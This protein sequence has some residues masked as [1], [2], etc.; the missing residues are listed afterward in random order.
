M[1]YKS[2]LEALIN[3]A[4]GGAI[5]GIGLDENPG[6]LY[7]PSVGATQGLGAANRVGLGDMLSNYERAMAN[8]V[9][10]PQTNAI[11]HTHYPQPNY[12]K[13]NLGA[14]PNGFIR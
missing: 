6:T 11:P 7:G 13:R 4:I 9:P 14:I 10:S 1:D 5:N 12:P 8:S 3:S 2:F